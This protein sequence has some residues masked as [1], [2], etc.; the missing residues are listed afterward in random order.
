MGAN[1]PSMDA[2]LMRLF[3]TLPQLALITVNHE[4]L[5]PTGGREMAHFLDLD[6]M[7]T[8]RATVGRLTLMGLKMDGKIPEPK[9]LPSEAVL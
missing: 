3:E 4:I 8:L 9:K 7:V 2:N 1:G 5:V 6:R